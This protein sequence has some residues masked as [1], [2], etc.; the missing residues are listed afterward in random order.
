MSRINYAIVFSSPLYRE[1]IYSSLN[2]NEVIFVEPVNE[3]EKLLAGYLRQGTLELGHYDAFIID[4]GSLKDTDEQIVESIE[5]IRFLDDTVRIIIIV[6]TRSNCG[7][8][9]QKC[10][11]NGIYNIIKAEDYIH[12]RENLERCILEGMSY[13]DALS[14]REVNEKS[15]KV[16]AAFEVEAFNRKKIAFLGSQHRMGTTHCILTA[17]FTL[18]KNGYLV[19]VVGGSNAEDYLRLMSS[20]EQQLEE[21]GHFSIDAIDFWPELSEIKEGRDAY[22]FILYDCGAMDTLSS[23]WREQFISAEQRILIIGSKPWEMPGVAEVLNNFQ[24]EDVRYLFNLVNHDMK[25]ELRKMLT[26][27]GV[28]NGI[29]FM[30]YRED[31]F[32]VSEVIKELL[33]I[34]PKKVKRG[35]FHRK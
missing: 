17:A 22:N 1:I 11:L 7:G 14:F 31:F 15:K 23:P 28:Q 10:F 27:A 12:V 30:D 6:S 5:A 18:R 2:K 26:A 3:D 13:K 20:Y 19:A 16:E 4:L 24:G 34:V 35:L 25:K 21:D 32:S 9:L 8:L 33:Q 29:Y